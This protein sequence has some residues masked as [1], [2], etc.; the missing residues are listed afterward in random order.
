MR[1]TAKTIMKNWINV[2]SFTNIE[3]SKDSLMRQL[4]PDDGQFSDDRIQ[5]F[6]S[7]SQRRDFL[8]VLLKSFA[9][10]IYESDEVKFGLLTQLFGG[11]EKSMQSD[12]NNSTF[13]K[14]GEINIL[15][16][17]DPSTGKS[18]LLK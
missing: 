2:V 4:N 17:G 6:N 5:Q 12:K 11:V 1:T 16:L 9:P 13:S 7:F 8:D 3:R 10:S 15:L 18:Q 14:R